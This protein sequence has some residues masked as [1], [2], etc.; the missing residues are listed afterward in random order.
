LDIQPR[1]PG[2]ILVIPKLHAPKLADLDDDLVA[3]V[4]RA[5]KDVVKMLEKA[6]K[7]DAFTIGINDGE[8]AGQVIAHLHVNIIPRF[9]G[10]GGSAIHSVV[11]NPPSEDIRE[12]A[13][14]IRSA[15]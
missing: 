15:I 7:P 11:H 4:F 1:S 8:E 10:D 2:H 5:T 3:E 14:R 12:T 6:L 13:E 9:R